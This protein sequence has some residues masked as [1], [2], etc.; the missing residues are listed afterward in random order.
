MEDHK[1]FFSFIRK[2]KFL[3]AHL[4]LLMIVSM[5]VPSIVLAEDTDNFR[6]SRDAV[7]SK[8]FAEPDNVPNGAFTYNVPVVVPPGR[9]GIQPNLQLGY[10]SAPDR[11]G[12][13]F[14]YGW[15]LNIPY[16]E[17]VSKMGVDNLYNQDPTHSFFYSSLSGELLPILSTTTIG[18]VLGFSLFASPLSF[19]KF[20]SQLA[21][22]D[23]SVVAAGVPIDTS[24]AVSSATDT[25]ESPPSV[26]STTTEIAPDSTPPASTT[27]E[28]IDTTSASSTTSTSAPTTTPSPVIDSPVPAPA[29]PVVD[30]NALTLE[31]LF[32]PD[33]AV[34]IPVETPVELTA[35]RTLTSKKFVTL[36]ADRKVQTSY[37]FYSTPLHYFDTDTQSYQEIDSRFASTSGGFVM[38]KDSYQAALDT[39]GSGHLLTITN[40][41]AHLF[42]DTPGVA[43]TTRLSGVIPTETSSEA[44]RNRNPHKV[45]YQNYFGTGI[46]LEI[47]TL[48]SRL[49]EEA[50]L[51][52]PSVLAGATGDYLE[53]PF[54]ISGD[55]A[56][57]LVTEGQRIS[58]AK[59]ITSLSSATILD[60]KGSATT[61]LPPVAISSGSV[62]SS[63]P[64]IIP[65]DIAYTASGTDITFTKRIP[66]SFLKDAIYPVRTDAT[67]TFYPGS[68]DGRLDKNN[69]AD[70]AWAS[71]HDA[72][73]GDAR[74]RAVDGYD[75]NV[76]E[77]YRYP[78]DAHYFLYRAFSPFDTSSIDDTLTIASATM[79]VLPAGYQADGTS[80]A[81]AYLGLVGPTTQAT[82]TDLV[83]DDYDQSATTLWSDKTILPSNTWS[84]TTWVGFPFNATGLSGVSKTGYTMVGFREGHDIDNVAPATNEDD[85]WG[86]SNSASTTAKAYLAVETSTSTTPS[87]PTGLQ[88][89]LQQN[90]V[91]VATSNPR[92]SALFQSASS[93]SLGA[94]YQIQVTA[95]STSWTSPYWDSG[96]LTLSSSTP[97]GVR[98]PQ[99]FATTTFPVD[100]TK[101]Y[102]RMKFWDQTGTQGTWSTTG[103]YF[104]MDFG[105]GYGAKVENGDFINYTHLLNGGGWTAND[106]R[107]WR[108]VFGS[109]TS[110]RIDNNNPAT[111]TFRWMLESIIDPNGNTMTYSYSKDSTTNQ[112]YPYKINYTSNG[113]SAGIGEIEFVRE[114]RP[115]IATTSY[116][117]FPVV[118]KQRIK[119]ILVRTNGQ[120]THRYQLTYKSGDNGY[121]SILTALQESGWDTGVGTTTL[122]AVS[123]NY[124]TSTANWTLNTDP[125]MWNIPQTFTNGTCDCGW[126]VA[127][128]NGDGLLDIT[129]ALNGTRNTYINTGSDWALSATWTLPT[130]FSNGSSDDGTELAD[131]NGDGLLD[132]V[133][134][135][136]P[137]HP[138]DVYL[139]N[140]NGWTL[141]TT[142]LFP[143]PLVVNSV[144]AGNRIA[145]VNGDGFADL[146]VGTTG[147]YINNTKNGWTFDSNWRAPHV[148]RD[149]T[150]KDYGLRIAD[151]N[152]DGLPDI[153]YGF[154]TSRDV[155]LNNGHGW[156]K[157][158][159]WV[160]PDGF[161]SGSADYG[162][163]LADVN[164]DGLV[165]I[166]KQNSLGDTVYLNT[167]KGWTQNTNWSIPEWTYDY[168]NGVDYGTRLEDTDGNGSV[169]ILRASTLAGTDVKR[170]YIKNGIK[171]D[172][173]NQVLNEKGG[174]T[175]VAYQAAAKYQSSGRTVNPKLP[176]V[177]D[178]VKTI[179]LDNG[180]GV[181]ATTTYSYA[182]GE[183]YFSTATPTDRKFA[184]FA[185]TTRT[186]DQNHTVRTYYHQ[187]DA[188]DSANG[189]YNDS[190][191]K[192]GRPYRVETL[193][194]TTSSANTYAR[195]INKWARA[196]Y[197]DGRNFVKLIQTLM[198]T[199]DGDSSHRDTAA[200][201]TYD[202]TTGNVT[203]RVSLGEVLGN[204]DGTWT[205]TGTD[206]AS[207]TYTYAAS[208]TNSVMS[209]PSEELVKDQS[210][211]TV[212]DTKW[213][214][215]N[216]SFGSVSA[217][218]QTK[219]EKLKSGSNYASTTK[220]YNSYGLVATS[221]DPLGNAT[222][223]VYDS[224]NLYPATATNA[225]SQNLTFAYDYSSGKIATS[226]DE[227]GKTIVTD[228]DGLDRPIKEKQPDF[229]T[230]T[231][232]VTRTAYTYTDSTSTPSSIFRSDY[233]SSAT[234]TDSYTYLDGWGRTLQTKK[235]SEPASGWA[236][237]DTIYNNIGTVDQESLPYFH[238]N[239]TYTT[240]T[241]ASELF[242]VYRYDPAGRVKTLADVL[243]TTTNT[244]NDWT[245]TV[246]DPLSN[247]KDLIKDA[248][249]NLANVVEYVTA[250]SPATT[251]YTWNLLGKLTKLTDASSNVRNFTYDTLGR[252]LSSEDL[253]ASVD[254]TF[255]STSRQYDDASNLI[256]FYSPNGI[257]TTY[258]YDALNRV[259]SE[260][261]TSTANVVDVSYTYD[262]CTNGKGRLCQAQAQNRA[263]TTY[264]YNP[265][266]LLAG[267]TV[268]IK[269][270]TGVTYEIAT[271]S[272]AYLRNGLIDNITCAATTTVVNRLGWSPL[273]QLASIDYTSGPQATSTY[274]QT[275]KYRLAN[276]YAKRLS[277]STI[278][279]DITY[280][281]DAVGN[282]TNLSDKGSSTARKNIDYV[283][284]GLYRLTSA[285]TTAVS[286]STSQYKK[287]YT[288]DTLG[289]IAADTGTTYTYAGT[290]FA[291]PDAVTSI[292]ANNWTYDNAGNALTSGSATYVYDYLYRLGTTSISGASTS[293]DFY[294]FDGTRV[295]QKGA[296]TTYSA[297]KL[298]EYT[299]GGYRKDKHIFVSGQL[300]STIEKIGSAT[301]NPRFVL[302]D[303]L[304]GSSVIAD[305]AGA[306]IQDLDYYPY[307]DIRANQKVNTFD[308]SRK[309]IGERYDSDTSLSYLNA[310]YYDGRVGKFTSQDPVARDVGMMG[311]MTGYILDV[312]Q[313][314]GA[315]DQTA[316]LSNPQML[317]SYSYS[318][319]NPITK[320]DPSGKIVFAAIPA[321]LVIAVGLSTSATFI[322]KYASDIASN[323][324][325]GAKGITN[326]LSGSSGG[327]S[328][329]YNVGVLG[330]LGGLVKNP[331]A[332]GI[333]GT[334]GSVADDVASGRPIN[335]GK[336]IV[337]GLISAGTSGFLKV[338]DTAT[339]EK[340]GADLVKTNAVR[341]EVTSNLLNSAL[342]GIAGLK[343]WAGKVNS[344]IN[345]ATGQNA[346][347]IQ[348][349]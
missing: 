60:G 247:K 255:G 126:R 334:V 11:E 337:T 186:N 204:S 268:K 257:G 153:L 197:A 141:S 8:Q 207:T 6:Y 91:G 299:P 293:T 104:V 97:V 3:S 327:F 349:K 16:I 330:P 273:E 151:V 241:T 120:L 172:M 51:R 17:R 42:I 146:I 54:E 195:T 189:E 191:A 53:I 65:I 308:D 24:P 176:F 82:A 229:I 165:D 200:S 279:E 271:T 292:G 130:D 237:R 240:A 217:G 109:S 228:Y 343:D 118:T 283:Y 160:L 142:W 112:G 300:V 113:G 298:Y 115:D 168:T 219:E 156:T 264:T 20:P 210:G 288:Y 154:T 342:T 345:N 150:Y 103:D 111:S 26:L 245:L 174:K 86:Y 340:L 259:K 199:F 58:G 234:T 226:S 262:A 72:S 333:V 180:F 34:S 134:A 76:A 331:I 252:L 208:S 107:G 19:L 89:E 295:L 169:D 318:V 302:A 329:A 40:K 94:N 96:K 37:R 178:T 12:S 274:D 276:K 192:I 137:L 98:S 132:V 224:Y 239:S 21:L 25:V 233:L 258:T 14:G 280:T 187:G 57:D 121:R 218:N 52:D 235:E 35:E 18:S 251:T 284:D 263:T 261:S 33:G 206:K 63:S 304:G 90:P 135:N 46:D 163:R 127:D 131:V 289:N 122:P 231:T 203:E 7:D 244:Y 313:A 230:P 341:G 175:T 256:E 159:S 22:L 85:W 196:S 136:Y 77:T 310:R 275:K 101:Y 93:T 209:L 95:S 23:T 1:G 277:G 325:N 243:G 55:S 38:T 248:Y 214:Y 266:G 48:D 148:F 324:A 253:H 242:T 183:Y 221:T 45:V 62:S 31:N 87:G 157:D 144:D 297:G 346:K 322:E 305:S 227:N 117:G 291:N 285:S 36:D 110:A 81:H 347:D 66:L 205:D 129:Q 102:W 49:I 278:V 323:V 179:S 133:H 296:T 162:N 5:L 74:F 75:I 158:P 32:S 246:T 59:S 212:K 317:N 106:K 2:Q 339:I 99:I 10:S 143:A 326:V 88:V 108:Y 27:T 303:Q 222:S 119:E 171:A 315:F 13:I 44:V 309:Y 328:Y 265:I 232:L 30:R 161:T 238:A 270:A 50:V 71:A 124:S 92:F 164:G 348:K 41:G 9:S 215:D 123:L 314:P 335:Q 194:G 138:S 320:S 116:Q 223:Y 236:T 188:N 114:D 149:S 184:G 201:T 190:Y 64:Q 311:N 287:T 105:N 213:T 294:A 260:D 155:Y 140:G 29:T 220:T 67:L 332:G 69:V 202:D 272:Y 70:T 290:G 185:S 80:D 125:S 79:Y 83:L 170:V 177:L 28:V 344:T 198:Q 301:A 84:T 281:Y 147:A 211:N 312:N 78:S 321:A 139:N 173:L 225:L 152:G 307:G 254:S 39:S 249:G 145:D 15:S 61:I 68:G 267:E 4:A 306:V 181:F 73:V 128:L 282:L 43:M 193:D 250:G 316:L 319:N 216:L 166:A 47:T 269:P 338:T 100:G 56:L 286:T 336:A 182:G 167:G